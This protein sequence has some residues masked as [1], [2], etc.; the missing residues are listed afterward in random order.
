MRVR[1]GRDDDSVGVSAKNTLNK[2]AF[3]GHDAG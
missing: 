3:M 1:S 2:L